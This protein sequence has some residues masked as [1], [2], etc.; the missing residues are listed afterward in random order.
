MSNGE[1]MAPYQ[2][3]LVPFLDHRREQ[4]V[5]CLDRLEGHVTCPNPE[6]IRSRAGHFNVGFHQSVWQRARAKNRKTGYL[7]GFFQQL[8]TLGHQF[9]RIDLRPREISSG[10]A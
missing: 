7:E 10:A 3:S 9:R 5:E 2:E 1:G 4:I 8:Q 6:L